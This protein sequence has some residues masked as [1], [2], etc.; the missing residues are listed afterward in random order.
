MQFSSSQYRKQAAAHPRKQSSSRH[1]SN[2]LLKV[3]YHLLKRPV[4]NCHTLPS[5][6]THIS[7]FAARHSQTTSIHPRIPQRSI[8][9]LNS[10][11]WD[12]PAVGDSCARRGLSF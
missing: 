4:D 2:R 6:M 12:V 1:G 8:A 7:V 10:S 3:Q 5:I 9:N 11:T